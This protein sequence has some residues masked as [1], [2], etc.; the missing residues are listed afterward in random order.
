VDLDTI[1]LVQQQ[2][3]LRKFERHGKHVFKF[4]N[5]RTLTRP[6]LTFFIITFCDSGANKDSASLG[7][8]NGESVYTMS[9]FQDGRGASSQGNYSTERLDLQTR[10]EGCICGGTN[11]Q[12]LS[13]LS[14][15]PTPGHDIQLQIPTIW[16]ERRSKGILEADEVR[17]DTFTE[18]RNQISLLSRRYLHLSQDQ[19][20][21]ESTHGH[22]DLSSSTVGL[23]IEHGQERHDSTQDSGF[24]GIHFQHINNDNQCTWEKDEKI[25]VKGQTSIQDAN[26]PVDSGA[27][28]NDYFD[29]TSNWG[30]APPH[31][32]HTTG[33]GEGS[34][35]TTLQLGTQMSAI[36]VGAGRIGM[37]DIDGG[38]QEWIEDQNTT[39]PNTNRHDI[40]RRV[41]QRL[42]SEIET[43]GNMGALVSSR[44][45]HFNQCTGAEDNIVC[46]TTTSTGIC[47]PNHRNKKRQFD[48]T[49]ICQQTRRHGI[50]SP[51]GISSRN[52]RT[53]VR[54]Q[55]RPP[56]SPHRRQTECDSGPTQQDEASARMDITVHSPP[57]PMSNMEIP[58]NNRRFC[59]THE[60][61]PD[62]ILEL[63][64]GPDSSSNGRL[65]TTVASERIIPIP[66]MATNS[67]RPPTDTATASQESDNDYPILANAALVAHVV[68]SSSQGT[69]S[70]PSHE[71]QDPGRLAIIQQ[72]YKKSGL[73]KGARSYVTHTTRGSTAKQYDGLWNKWWSWCQKQVPKQDPLAYNPNMVVEWLTDNA[74]YSTAHLNSMRSSVASVFA[75]LYPNHTHLAY[76]QSVQ[77]FF[78][79]HKRRQPIME[80]PGDEI[81][82]LRVVLQH[83]QQWGANDQLSLE[84]LQEKVMFLLCVATIWRPRSDIGKLQHRDLEWLYDEREHD[85]MIGV[86]ILARHPK[87]ANQKYTTL[88]SHP[89]TTHMCPVK[90][91]WLFFQQSQGLRTRLPADHS[92]FLAYINHPR[93]TVSSMDEKTVA[94]KLKQLMAAAGVDVKRYSTHS[95]RS[96]TA[97]AAF[98]K[99]I[100][101]ADIKTQGNWSHSAD[102]LERY[103][104][105]SKNK[106]QKSSQLLQALILDDAEKDT[107]SGVEAEASTIVLGTPHN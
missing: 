85:Q 65:Q 54:K 19:A 56:V 13:A 39:S 31:S 72:A 18:T 23:H 12:G 42:G 103:Y 47:E 24:F 9:T 99:G 86:R 60:P 79:A 25:G 66:S 50:T 67:P 101:I 1:T 74:R 97:S 87:E 44:K 32:V 80:R 4:T 45:R 100:K 6:R 95:I 64:T 36:R 16:H 30:R 90:T 107:T 11:S 98:A 102:T 93:Q 92:L 17:N 62:E 22:G 84:K 68:E 57:T 73:T 51:P 5:Y 104:L 38:P 37:V 35:A 83:I 76:Q 48:R 81:W 34:Q 2:I 27:I 69:D 26:L 96:A 49:Q 41:G 88:A 58:T 77:A 53:Y 61:S 89:S 55:H 105:K 94:E 33:L 20:R 82:D 21:N 28:G 3:N 78:K 15:F 14:I 71:K 70:H 52:P 63:S 10:F 43:T 40:R 106:L 7:L 75:V 59:F 8:Q 29:A 91:L 46:N